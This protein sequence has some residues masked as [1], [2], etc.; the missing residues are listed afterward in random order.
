MYMCENGHTFCK[1]EALSEPE[2]GEDENSY[3]VYSNVAAKHCP[4]CNFVEVSNKDIG[5]YLQKITGI[6]REEIFAEI[7][8]VNKRRKKL[9]DHEYVE[10]VCI[11]TGT[12]S[13][14]ILKALKDKYLCYD[15]FLKDLK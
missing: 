3:D 1:S 15:Q 7:K 10:S 4:I 13:Q 9:K 5:L 2:V 12:T 11:R 14:D 6:T 8:A